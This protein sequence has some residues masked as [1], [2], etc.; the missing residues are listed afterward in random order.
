MRRDSSGLLTI[1]HE[2]RVL[3]QE[4]CETERAAAVAAERAAAAQRE[5]EERAW[6][7]AMASARERI[8][9]AEQAARD[10]AEQAARD[11]EER[12]IEAERE[13]HLA[14][15]EALEDCREALEEEADERIARAR[16]PYFV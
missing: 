11:E 13:V 3:E 5:E 6:T 1:L 15:W 16:R 10:E 14:A 7:I 4:R 12:R 9:A 2:L 8:A